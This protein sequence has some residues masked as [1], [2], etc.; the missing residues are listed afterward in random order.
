MFQPTSVHEIKQGVLSPLS[1]LP[2]SVGSKQAQGTTPAAPHR[3]QPS[4]A[5]RLSYVL[6]SSP[7]TSAAACNSHSSCRNSR[8]GTPSKTEVSGWRPSRRRCLLYN[9]VLLPTFLRQG[10]VNLWDRC[11]EYAPQLKQKET[12]PTDH[13]SCPVVICKQGALSKEA[14]VSAVRLQVAHLHRRHPG[15]VTGLCCRTGGRRQRTMRGGGGSLLVAR[16]TFPKVFNRENAALERN[17]ATQ[18]AAAEWST[19]LSRASV[20]TGCRLA[21]SFA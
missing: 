2:A 1:W 14:N 18:V 10:P 11:S 19:I 21:P 9:A 12:R 6:L 5:G 3:G 8:C 15:E 13:T 20:S 16:A 4:C 17:F 7:S